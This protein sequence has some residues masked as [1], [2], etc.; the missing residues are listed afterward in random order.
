LATTVTIMAG[1][2]TTIQPKR[3]NR[4]YSIFSSASWGCLG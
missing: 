3:N 1:K 2:H 4:T